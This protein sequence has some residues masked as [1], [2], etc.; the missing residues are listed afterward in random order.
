MALGLRF[1]ARVGKRI[2]TNRHG[3]R[4]CVLY[5]PNL[6]GYGRGVLL[7]LGW[8]A[9]IKKLPYLALTSFALNYLGDNLDGVLARRCKQVRVLC[10]R[11]QCSSKGMPFSSAQ[12]R[13]QRPRVLISPPQSVLLTPP[14]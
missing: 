7:L 11:A 9:S 3:R 10:K 13:S 6:L 8:A 1:L 5:W 4:R 2:V 12:K 14:P